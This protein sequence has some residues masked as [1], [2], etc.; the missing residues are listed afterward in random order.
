MKRLLFTLFGVLAIIGV[1]MAQRTVSGTISG[2]DGEVL[3]GA[4]ISAKGTSTGAR[5]GLDGKYSLNVPTG[6]DV[7]VVSYTGY[8]AQEVSLGASNVLDVVLASGVQLTET[9]VTALGITR[10]EKAL[11]YSLQ[12]VNG[13]DL[14]RARSTNIVSALSG[15]IAGAQIT[16]SSNLG[17]SS[18]IILRGARAIQGNNQPLFVV[19]GVPIDNSNFTTAD[20]ARGALGYDYGNAAQDINSDDV[21]S[22][23]V[24]KGATAAAL[25]G[26]RAA[27]GVIVITTKKGNKNKKK[28]LGVTF[29]TDNFFNNVAFLP[30]Y[31]NSYGGGPD[32]NNIRPR[33][34]NDNSGFYK[35]SY[36]DDAGT[37]YQSFD[38]VPD[39]SYD[40]SWGPSFGSNTK[41]YLEGF[42]GAN[43]GSF[44]DLSQYSN[45]PITYRPWNSW[46]SYDA[47]HYGKSVPWAAQPDNIK[48]YYDQGF[49]S[50]NNLSFSG[51]N[52][53]AYFR[54]S[55]TNLYQKGT[56]PS[57]S[58]RRNSISINTGIQATDRLSIS[59]GFNYI[60]NKGAGRGATGYNG[61]GSN[62]N[63]WFQRQ[64]N[65]DELRDYINPSD[66]TL[67][68]SWNRTSAEEASPL[69]WDNPFWVAKQRPQNDQRD[70]L[71]GN[72]NIS[73]KLTDWLTLTGRAMTDFYTETREEKI[74]V[75]SVDLSK[76]SKDIYTVNENNFD[77]I[78]RG[79]KQFDN[80]FSVDA[81]VGGNR[82]DRKNRRNYNSTQGGLG[83][84][85]FYNLSNS[86]SN[87][88]VVD[89]TERKRINSV[90]GSVSFGYN[91]TF[92]LDVTARNDWSSTL[93]ADNN[94]YF[95]PSVSGSFI[96][97]ELLPKSVTDVLSYAKLRASWANVGSDTDP[98]RVL[99]PVYNSRANF[100]S[101]PLVT[102]ANVINNPNLK[103]EST[104]S[105]EVG[106]ELKFFKNRVSLD[107]TYYKSTTKDQI[108]SVDQSST[109]GYTSRILNV[110]TIENNG[111]ELSLNT[112][113]IL[114]RDFQWDLGINF[115]RNRNKVKELIDGVDNIRLANFPFSVSIQAQEG[116]PYGVIV[117]TDYT[118]DAN[119]NKLVNQDGFYVPTATPVALGSVLADFT[120]GATTSLTYKNISLSILVDYQSGGN[121]FS[122]SNMWGKYS[123]ILQETTE[124][125]VRENGVV[126]SGVYEEGSVVNGEDV[127]GQP[128]KSN[129]GAIDHFFENGGYVIARADL[130]D[131]SYIK[132]REARLSWNLPKKWF[133]NKVQNMSFSVVG[134]NLAILFKNIPNIDPEAAISASNIQGSEGG[135]LPTERSIGFNLTI[136]F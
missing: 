108:A 36:T 44:G 123:G 17:G 109:T 81:F 13:E 96:L 129:I 116:Q 22:V 135:Q 15:K 7:L 51:G 24:L 62:F 119:G 70:R 71:F 85:G 56:I 127:S 131:A 11:G 132:L 40:G 53:K 101:N 26:S 122:L 97:S 126:V 34:Y 50:S 88:A 89:N 27:N 100:G 91:S 136:G 103:P 118:Y 8:T 112:T 38:L 30:D 49:L 121:L 72:A 102:V 128:N 55:Y 83:T 58:L 14:V 107:A 67:Q 75:G 6:T 64:L 60:Q 10:S 12:A 69:Y 21:E 20:Q 19:D 84:P 92:Y 94:S 90:F 98:Y 134:R 74:A 105:Y 113:P 66:P 79:N 5:T 1:S 32:A 110:G 124:G 78:L 115:A 68:R 86:I 28:P 33:G 43:G 46:D 25:Y 99:D 133:N 73:L 65:M 114:T 61:T 106:T 3:I 18:R 37:T 54:G 95:Y 125:G 111:I 23:S 63:Q 77:L 52:E 82:L 117:G 16:S 48:D 35:T 93:P 76:Y 104:S 42:A 9:V 31:Q 87:L 2:D 45:T 47:Q 57:S 4:S 39:Y 80:K 130:Y 41:G 29:S 59:T 120:G